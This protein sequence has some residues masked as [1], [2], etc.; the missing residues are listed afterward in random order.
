MTACQH[1]AA[2]LNTNGHGVA[3]TSN[4]AVCGLKVSSGVFFF[5]TVFP[6]F[7]WRS[8]TNTLASSFLT[9]SAWRVCSRVMVATVPDPATSSLT[10]ANS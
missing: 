5:Y 10:V 7:K 4:I 6:I 3:L 9:S 8:K 2:L 1:L